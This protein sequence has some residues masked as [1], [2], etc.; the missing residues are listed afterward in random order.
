MWK[1]V[2]VVAVLSGLAGPA[3]ADSSA[4]DAEI[5]QLR[6]VRVERLTQ[7]LGWLSLVG[8]QWIE[9]GRH[10]IGSAPDNDLVLAIGPAHLGH[11]TLDAGTVTLEP[12][13]GAEFL[14]DNAAA[15]GALTLIPDTK[16][17]PTQITF[18]QGHSGFNLIERGGR[19]ALRVRDAN[20]ATRTGFA[21]IQYYPA[22]PTWRI[23]ARFEPHPDG[24][25]IPIANV[26]NQIEDTPNPG[27]V[28]F[29]R[30]GNTYR[31]EALAEDDGSLF[32]VFAD[33]TSG[34]ETYGGGRQLDASAPKDGEVIVDF[35]LAYNPP[36][37]FN[38]YSTCPLPPPENRLNLV[39][40]AGEKKYHRPH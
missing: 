39:V 32:F 2:L 33:R 20:A 4:F 8:M 40:T 27:A 38:D 15:K 22:D 25:T 11:V 13:D 6:T 16:G 26:I 9:Q 37:A 23:R 19:F 36:C 14:V 29:E 28:V 34:P 31:M 18:D 7:P 3:V 1:S 12:L 35:N 30:D 24:T 21:G 5:A 17:T 10:S